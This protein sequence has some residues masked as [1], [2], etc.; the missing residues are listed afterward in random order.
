[1]VQVWPLFAMPMVYK[2]IPSSKILML[3][4]AGSSVGTALITIVAL[5]RWTKEMPKRQYC[6]Y[7]QREWHR[8]Q[9]SSL[10]T[11][12]EKH[13]SGLWWNFLDATGN[14]PLLKTGIV[15]GNEPGVMFTDQ[16]NDEIGAY[17]QGPMVMPIANMC[18]SQTLWQPVP[19][20]YADPKLTVQILS[21]KPVERESGIAASRVAVKVTGPSVMQF[22]A[23]NIVDWSIDE[24]RPVRMRPDC[25]CAWVMRSSGYKDDLFAPREWEFW[26]VVEHPPEDGQRFHLEFSGQYFEEITPNEPPEVCE[27]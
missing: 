27:N 4:A 13:D 9:K 3:I 7:T 17:T 25:N 21:W 2:L 18:V 24:E 15:T 23:K 11:V 14:K 12:M 1:M 22:Q 10:Q 26:I 16:F 20:R 6:Q 19:S 8:V 5:P